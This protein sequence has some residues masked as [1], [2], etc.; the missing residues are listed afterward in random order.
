QIVRGSYLCVPVEFLAK[1]FGCTFT[2]DENGRCASLTLPDRRVFQF[3]EGCIGCTVDNRIE[4]MLCEAIFRNKSL[5]ISL[6]W[7]CRFALNWQV[8][9]YDGVLYATDHYSV[10]SRYLSWLLQDLL[11][12]DNE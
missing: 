3:A 12:G 6:E 5:Y 2:E 4:A 1:A 11:R 10:L 9:E 8:S 7:F